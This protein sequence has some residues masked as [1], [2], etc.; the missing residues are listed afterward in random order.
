[1]N[2]GTVFS[3]SEAKP[4]Q[5]E[6]HKYYYSKF[7]VTLNSN[8]RP[9]DDSHEM[10]LRHIMRNLI[11]DNFYGPNIFKNIRILDN[12]QKEIDKKTLLKYVNITFSTEV[13]KHVK[14]GRL[15]AHIIVD[16]KHMTKIHIKA[17][18]LRDELETYFG[19]KGHVDIKYFPS[20]EILQDYIAKDIIF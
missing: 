3:Y 11:D 14:G 9:T 8:I 10:E 13:G 20:A 17:N 1:M 15:H 7:L 12:S 2:D 5:R 4:I 18:R 6:R 19:I 16:T